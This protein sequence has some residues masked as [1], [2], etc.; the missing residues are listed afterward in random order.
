MDEK[1]FMVVID[2]E[3][4]TIKFKM[5]K[6][7]LTVSSDPLHHGFWLLS[8]DRGSLPEVYKGR[9]TKKILA[10]KAAEQYI[11]SRKKD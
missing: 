5:D 10:V 2:V 7:V 6:N 3:D 4:S 9:Y 8:L 1:D 11:E